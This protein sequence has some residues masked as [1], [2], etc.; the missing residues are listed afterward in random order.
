MSL[1]WVLLGEAVRRGGW[2]WTAL[3]TPVLFVEAVL[4]PE[5]SFQVIAATVVLVGSDLVHRDEGVSRWRALVRTRAYVVTGVVCTVVWCLYLATQDALGAFI[6]YYLVFGPGHAESGA[7]PIPEHAAQ[8]FI[9]CFVACVVVAAVTLWLMGVGLIRRRP[10]SSRHWV[11]FGAALTTA[12]Y[13]EKGLGRFDDGHLLQVVTVAL[14]LLAIW[15]ALVLSALDDTVQALVRGPGT[16][17]AGRRVAQ[18]GRPRPGLA[19][20]RQPA[21]VG[22]LVLLLVAFPSVHQAA[23]R[24]PGNN[25]TYVGGEQT[26]GLGWASSDALDDQLLDDLRTVV[27]TYTADGPVFDFTNSPGYFYYLL[28]QDPPTSYFHISMAVPEFTQEIVIDQLEKSR[29]ELVVFDG[30]FGLPGWDGPHNEVRHYTLS[31]YLLD[32]WTPVVRTHNVLFLIRNDML[33]D[34]PDPPELGRG[35]ELNRLWFAAPA[36][37]VGDTA[38]FLTSEPTGEKLTLEVGSPVPTRR[39][40]FRGWAYDTSNDRS[41]RHVVAVADGVVIESVA[42]SHTRPDVAETLGDPDAEMSG[43]AGGRDTQLE[44]ELSFYAVYADG[45]AHPLAGAEPRDSLSRPGETPIPV[46]PVPATGAVDE[47]IEEMV[48]VSSVEVPPE[49]D[50]ASYRLAELSSSTGD[51]GDAELELTDAPSALA[52]RERRILVGTLPLAG[53]S[54]RVRVGSCLQWHGYTGDTLYLTQ[55]D[56]DHPVDKIVLSGVTRPYQE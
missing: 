52:N 56:V 10:L 49:T 51:L 5:A 17:P 42:S 53:D 38:N 1:V 25:V 26:P 39:I 35:P 29:P 55:R 46:S 43:F 54:I 16:S 14:P 19:A 40:S 11:A 50:L 7:L 37:D 22:A 4:V 2:R 3:L 18:S 21:S 44:G 12:L 48:D 36:C 9:N 6:D 31:Q 45:M 34:L 13:A 24:A 30:P 33:D 15:V 41:A 8:V 47:V 28:G 32:G 20:V 27:D 23:D